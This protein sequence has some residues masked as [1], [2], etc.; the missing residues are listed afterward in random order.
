MTAMEVL[1]YAI[2]FTVI[3][4]GWALLMFFVMRTNRQRRAKVAM[5][6]V[7]RDHVSLYFDEYFPS[8]INNFDLVTKSHYKDWSGSI[9]ERLGN[10]SK[11]IKTADTG[12]KDI[13]KRLNSLE[14]KVKKLES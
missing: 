7:P 11:W 3:I 8:M 13:D 9:E 1:A 6:E 5:E 14:T 2:V 12:K 10:V 4:V